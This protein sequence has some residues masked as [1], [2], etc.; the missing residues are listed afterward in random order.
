MGD[1]P[2]PYSGGIHVLDMGFLKCEAT[3]DEGGQLH[4]QWEPDPKTLTKELRA[5]IW[6]LYTPWRDD[7]LQKWTDQTGKRSM[8]ITP[9]GSE[10]YL[11]KFAP[12]VK[13]VEERM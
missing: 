5:Q 11:T 9:R 6:D 10:I 1:P 4:C 7:L 2:I 12:G 8:C 13:P 3:I